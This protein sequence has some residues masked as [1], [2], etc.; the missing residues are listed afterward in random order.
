MNWVN[1]IEAQKGELDHHGTDY[2]ISFPAD[3]GKAGEQEHC[4]KRTQR[5]I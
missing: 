3:N 1:A 5:Q 4:G 2:A